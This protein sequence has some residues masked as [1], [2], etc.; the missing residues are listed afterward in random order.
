M[1]IQ[2]FIKWVTLSLWCHTNISVTA[3]HQCHPLHCWPSCF[4]CSQHGIRDSQ[5]STRSL[6]KVRQTTYR[7]ISSKSV[8]LI[9]TMQYIKVFISSYEWFVCPLHNGISQTFSRSYYT[10]QWNINPQN[11]VPH[12]DLLMSC[13]TPNV[14]S[15]SL[16]IGHWC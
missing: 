8:C 15:F 11:L 7:K 1:P 9:Y 16:L 14:F 3:Y 13:I 4:C 10:R 2:W 5:P 12:G 6:N